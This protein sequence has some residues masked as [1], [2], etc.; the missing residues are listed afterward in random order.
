MYKPAGPE[1]SCPCDSN[2]IFRECCGADLSAPPKGVI[3]RPNVLSDKKCDDMVKYL[4]NQPM[5]WLRVTA[6][7]GP[8]QKQQSRL[9]PGRVTRA[10]HLGKLRKKLAM[11]VESQLKEYLEN[12]LNHQLEWYEHPDVM[13]YTKGGLY[14]THADADNFDQANAIWTRFID[15]DYS[16]LIYLS[17]KFE[18][19]NITFNRFGFSYHPKKGDMLLFPSD[20]RY[21]HTAEPVISGDRYVV[22]SWCAVKGSRRVKMQPPATAVLV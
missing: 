1:D 19:G 13:Y 7:S 9:D 17:D 15:R 6:S 18:G 22:V 20:N 12:E 8:F 2:I 21:L 4:K 3:I 14:N 11:L 16:V 10:V 5:D